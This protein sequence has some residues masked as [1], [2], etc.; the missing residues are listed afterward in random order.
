MT[1][2][3]YVNVYHD[4]ASKALW[5]G[6]VCDTKKEAINGIVREHESL[7]FLKTIEV[8]ISPNLELE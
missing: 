3:K 1:E 7:T 5:T 6:C 8:E 4:A 2:T